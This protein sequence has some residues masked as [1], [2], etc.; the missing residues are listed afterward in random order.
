MVEII[1]GYSAITLVVGLILWV[2][3]EAYVHDKQRTKFMKSICPGMNVMLNGEAF[4]VVSVD[5]KFDYVT[6]FNIYHEPFRVDKHRLYPVVPYK[7]AYHVLL[8]FA[9]KYK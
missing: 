6:V 1:I 2:L 7:T 3:F 9:R 8:E 5:N 4:Q